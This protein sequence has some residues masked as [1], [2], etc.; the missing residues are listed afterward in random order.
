VAQSDLKL[1][2]C[3][4]DPFGSGPSEALP[5]LVGCLDATGYNVTQRCFSV[6]VTPSLDRLDGHPWARGQAREPRRPLLT[7]I[8][9][10]SLAGKTGFRP[11]DLI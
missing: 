8:S 5:Q 9:N 11:N 4:V 1:R 6:A 10:L 2:G 3:D 7:A